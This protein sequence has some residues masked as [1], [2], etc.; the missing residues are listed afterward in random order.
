MFIGP[1]SQNSTGNYFDDNFTK[2][3]KAS[4]LIQNTLHIG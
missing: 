2:V 4:N 1:C 3:T